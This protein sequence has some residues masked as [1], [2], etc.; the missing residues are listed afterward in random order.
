[1]SRW[2]LFYKFTDDLSINQPTYTTPVEER[3]KKMRTREM[4][5]WIVFAV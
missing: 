4:A 5:Q 1:M 2:K 3:D